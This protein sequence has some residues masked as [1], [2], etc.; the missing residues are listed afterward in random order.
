MR[1]IAAVTS[2]MKQFQQCNLVTTSVYLPRLAPR[3]TLSV[4]LLPASIAASTCRLCISRE[5]VATARVCP[6]RL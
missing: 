1:N 6:A 2:V 5:I 4:Q 3:K